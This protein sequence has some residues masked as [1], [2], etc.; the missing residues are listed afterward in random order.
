MTA[1]RRDERAEVFYRSRGRL[2]GIAYRML[3]TR[4]DAED[5]VQDAYIRWHNADKSEIET[6]EGWLTTV[7]TRLSIDRL[8]KAS[9]QRET[10]IGPWLPEPL[11]VDK[12]DSPEMRA[13]LESAV[14]LA[15][16][17]M[18][19]RLSPLE[20][21]VFLLHDVFDL[22]HAE[23][24]KVV[25]KSETA[26]RQIVSRARARVRSD[27]SRFEVD[28]VT[29]T[30]LIKKFISA[31]YTGDAQTLM[32]IFADDVSLTSDGGGKVNAA[33]KILYGTKRL[34]NLHT[35]AIRKYPGRLA[36]YMVTLNGEP[37]LIEYADGVPFA[38]STF[39]IEDGRIMALYRMMN[40]DKL[41]AFENL[42]EKLINA[43]VSQRHGDDRHE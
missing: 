39:S 8:R 22:A 1:V 10:Y 18:L 24:A 26:I 3:G 4:A 19:E 6:P 25:A 23:I 20:R 2:F 13:E 43:Q 33:K 28:A 41:R 17:V 15:F 34:A 27:R 31:S 40:P 7:V 9:V 30:D 14:S 12:A 11:L 29:R 16:L 21:A 37:G 32:S 36:A 35:V 5:I 42:E 38:A